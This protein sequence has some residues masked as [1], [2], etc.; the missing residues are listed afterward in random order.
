MTCR[1]KLAKE[2]PEYINDTAYSG[3]CKG[4]PS[5]YDYLSDPEFCGG[6]SDK[7]EMCTRCWDR[8]ILESEACEKR[9]EANGRDYIQFWEEAHTIIDEALEKRDRSVSVFL[10]PEYGLSLAVHPW[11]EPDFEELHRKYTDGKITANDF[12]RIFGLAPIGE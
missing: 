9:L 6:Y 4:C 12:R 2:H 5:E 1:E 11:P 10:H 7:K 8:E 3:G